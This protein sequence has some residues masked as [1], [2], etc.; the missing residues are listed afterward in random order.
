M[1]FCSVSKNSSDLYLNFQGYYS[2]L[3]HNLM[4]LDFFYQWRMSG[5]FILNTSLVFF[6]L[7]LNLANNTKGTC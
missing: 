4:P 2:F 3:S 6:E 5:F 1:Q 7:G